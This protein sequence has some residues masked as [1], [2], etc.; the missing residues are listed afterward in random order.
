MDVKQAKAYLEDFIEYAEKDGI[1][2]PSREPYD[3]A[4]QALEKQIP[5]LVLTTRTSC[6][7]TFGRCPGC[8][9]EIDEGS[10][11]F[12]H[13]DKNCLQLIRWSKEEQDV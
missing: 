12:Y 5:K 11:P 9:K 3:L 2:V 6:G 13:I 8:G 7:I 1:G 10:D 4:I